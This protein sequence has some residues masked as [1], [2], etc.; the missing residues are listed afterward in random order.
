MLGNLND[1]GGESA[2]PGIGDPIPIEAHHQVNGGY[3]TMF[4]I[5]TNKYQ[6]VSAALFLDGHVYVLISLMVDD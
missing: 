6:S 2:E 5:M 1:I 4:V 3:G